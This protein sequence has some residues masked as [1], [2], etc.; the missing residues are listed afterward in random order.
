M[1]S[2]PNCDSRSTI[3]RLR[4]FLLSSS[5]VFLPTIGESA[6]IYSGLYSFG[7][8]LT[9]AGNVFTATGGLIGYPSGR[10]SNGP[11]WAEQ[12]ATDYIGLPSHGPSI[13]GGNNHAWGGARTADEIPPLAPSGVPPTLNGQVAQFIGDGGS[14]SSGDLVTIWGG[15]NDV[16]DTLDSGL[17]IADPAASAANIGTALD[18]ILGAGAETVLILNLPN[19]GDTPAF[20]GGP[21]EGIVSNWTLG[22]NAALAAQIDA[23]RG[24]GVTL[25]EADIFALSQDFQ[26]NPG[27][28]GLVNLTDPVFPD[29][30]LDPATS[31][32]WDDVHPTVAVHGIFAREAATVVGIPE[33]S[34]ALLAL[35]SSVLLMKRRR[36]V[37]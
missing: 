5:L 26:A 23:R 14:F 7:D 32:Y 35:A 6:G 34:S 4:I 1:K 30:T 22:F 3:R 18:A 15:P 28:Y 17:G 37:A 9:D 21:A 24:P 20:R 11:T 27:D 16:F 36:K 25:F 12:L 31:A 8:S 13:M 2:Q 10:F 29:L 19:L 33:P